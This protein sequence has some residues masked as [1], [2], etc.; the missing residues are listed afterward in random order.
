MALPPEYTEKGHPNYGGGRPRTTSFSIEDMEKLGVE[1]VNWVI[2]NKPLHLSQWYTIEKMITYNKWK[3]MIQC[4]EF[5]PYYEKALKL[6][7][8]Q[9][10]DKESRVRDSISQRWQRTYFNDLRE[11]EDKEVVFKEE[12]KINAQAK[13]N[14]N[15]NQNASF[16]TNYIRVADDSNTDNTV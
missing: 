4:E 14:S 7:G 9:Y 5:L 16:Q 12:T 1:M 15:Q 3:A 8:I 11:L 13:L 6:I 2:V 10:I